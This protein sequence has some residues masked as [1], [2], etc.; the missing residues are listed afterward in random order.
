MQYVDAIQSLQKIER[1]GSRIPLESWAITIDSTCINFSNEM[2]YQKHIVD[3]D[4]KEPYLQAGQ[5]NL[6]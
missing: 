3:Y 4:P 2:I 6:N 5:P 1:T